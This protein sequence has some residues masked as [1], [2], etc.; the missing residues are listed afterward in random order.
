MFVGFLAQSPVKDYISAETDFNPSLGY[1][2]PRLKHRSSLTE[3]ST[4]GF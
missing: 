3:V 2:V 4:T 1:S